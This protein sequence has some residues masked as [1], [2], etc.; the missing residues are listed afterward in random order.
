MHQIGNELY[1][2]DE[3]LT[4]IKKYQE[5]YGPFITQ[6]N[7]NKLPR[8]VTEYIIQHLPYYPTIIKKPYQ[9]IQTFQNLYCTLPLTKDAIVK[10]IS[11]Q[12]TNYDLCLSFIKPNL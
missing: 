5:T 6:N 1:T 2:E 10:F 8:D 12:K 9:N 7:Y 4:I 3:L 11:S